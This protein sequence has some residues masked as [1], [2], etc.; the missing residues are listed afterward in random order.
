MNLILTRNNFRADGIFGILSLEN[1]DR[2]GVT[3]EHSYEDSDDLSFTPKV[4][5][6]V[7]TC[8]RHPPNRLP[9]ETFMLQNVPD[10]DGKPVD[11]ILIHI[12]NFNHDSDGCILIGDQVSPIQGGYLAITSSKI[13]FEKFMAL[14]SG[15]DQF[16]L[17]IN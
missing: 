14:Q 7:Y 1:G 11:G 9:Y 12:G 3:L 8:V 17:T 6:G 10:F 5:D 16:Q 2:F 13:T 15:I 4:A